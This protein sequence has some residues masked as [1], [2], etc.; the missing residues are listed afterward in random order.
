[1]VQG[2]D[3]VFERGI[4]FVF[5][6]GFYTVV[7]GSFVRVFRGIRKKIRWHI[8]KT[9]W[10]GLC[11]HCERSCLRCER[12]STFFFEGDSFLYSEG[13][14]EGFVIIFWKDDGGF[15]YYISATSRPYCNQF[16]VI[17]FD[18]HVQRQ[19]RFTIQIHNIEELQ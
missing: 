17:L 12:E 15:S 9:W 8:L 14:V 6:E 3:V 19:Y 5:W 18:N 2:F 16:Q 10:R 13:F 4:L 1:M 7:W 11:L